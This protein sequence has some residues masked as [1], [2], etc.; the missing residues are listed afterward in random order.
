MSTCLVMIALTLPV[1]PAA[2]GTLGDKIA[3]FC[4][5]NLGKQVGGGE[6]AH[7]ASE[8]LK[9]SGGEPRGKDDPNEGDYVWGKLIVKLE[10]A[11]KGPKATGKVSDLKP[12][13]ILQ[14][15]DLKFE[16]R[17]G[18]GTYSLTCPH[19]TAVVASIEPGGVVKVYHQNFNGKREVMEATLRTNDLKEGWIRAYRPAA[20]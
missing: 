18:K 12:G 4:K 9:E 2:E 5:S 1:A 3:A 20:K 13:D 8:A 10:S 11:A 6:C 16:G 17:Q 7:L 19:H 14:F 15:R